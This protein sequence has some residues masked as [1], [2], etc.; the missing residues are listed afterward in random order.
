METI[1]SVAKKFTFNAFNAFKIFAV[2]VI[3]IIIA[4]AV[5]L[6][7]FT[8]AE[9]ERAVVTTFGKYSHVA[10]PGLNFKIPFVQSATTYRTDVRSLTLTEKNDAGALKGV[11]TYT[12]DNQEVDIVFTIF[13]RLKPEN[14]RFI[15]E[16]AQDYKERLFNI[17][18]DRLKAEMGKINVEHLAQKR[19]E[20]RDSIRAVLKNDAAV[21]GLDVTDFQLTNVDY[22]TSFRKAVEQAA[23]AKAMVETREQE[24]QQAMRIA[25]RAKIDAEGKANAQREEAKGAADAR[26]LQATAEARAIELQGEAQAKAI[27]AQGE[28]LAQNARLVELRK[29]ERWDG[30]LPVQMLS[31][32][33]PFMN[34]TAAKE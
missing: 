23:A 30:K 24:K 15:Y 20:L 3:V 26:L 19:G 2:V 29:A 28:A 4:L 12:I 34:Y 5:L 10:G 21:L 9:Y 1:N 11:N 33:V 32:V 13:Y 16:N 7:M 27:K 17:A 22:T 18:I 6:A 31:G 8:V 14:V 25:E